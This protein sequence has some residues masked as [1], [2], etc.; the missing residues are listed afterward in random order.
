MCRVLADMVLTGL[1]GVLHLFPGIPA[2]VPARFHSLRAP[3]AFLVSAERR[4]EQVDY[5]LV[6]ALVGGTLRVEN[7]WPSKQLMV[8]ELQEDR[9]SELVGDALIE[10]ETKAECEYFLRPITTDMR[11][12][13]ML[14]FAHFN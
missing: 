14:N 11:S 4:A 1:D 5:I 10:V 6:R 12:I 9:A 8:I 2:G 13:S 7:P 3:G